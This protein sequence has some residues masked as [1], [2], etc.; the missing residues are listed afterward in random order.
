MLPVEICFVVFSGLLGACVGSFLNVCIYRL[1][2]EKLS[3]SRPKRSFCP[4]CGTH[5][6]W[7]DNVPLLS[8]LVLGGRCRSCRA[9][10][11]SRYLLVE[12]ITAAFFALIALRFLTGGMYLWG[13]FLA[14]VVLVAVLIVLAFVDWDLR[15]LP[16]EL[17][18]GGMIAA[19]FVVVAVPY[20]HVRSVDS[21][22]S[23][24]LL[25]ASGAL[26]ALGGGALGTGAVV[27]GVIVAGAFGGVVG[28]FGYRFYWR[29]T[30]KGEIRPLKDGLLGGGIGAVTAAALALALLWPA[31]LLHPRVY[32]LWAALTGMLVGAGL[33]FLVGEIGSRVFRKP[34]MGFGDV[35]LMGLLGAFT[36]WSGVIAGF[37]I[38]CILGSVVGVFLLVRFRSRYLAFGPFL[39]LGCLVIIL[40][41]ESF[42]ALANWYLGLLRGGMGD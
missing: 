18:I 25:R 1:P 38:A 20:F 22:L 14:M 39:A 17:T 16:D 28:L 41:P 29:W 23:W 10:I 3:V 24:L 37:F 19:P 9:G 32:S 34:A 21:S 15:I 12:A 6:R 8:W 31:G 13:P 36:G 33:V 7:Y 4:L 30:R 42:E 27:F 35:K 11:S 5:I 40:W 2:R 26:E